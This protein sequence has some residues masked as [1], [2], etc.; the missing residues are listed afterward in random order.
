[1]TGKL[2]L[3]DSLVLFS[4]SCLL[5]EDRIIDCYDCDSLH[6][7]RCRDPF[8]FTVA[9]KDQPPLKSCKGC[10]VKMVQNQ[11]RSNER[12][13]RTCT[14]D[15]QINLFMVDHVCM[16]EGSGKG[17]MCFCEEDRCNSA[18]LCKYDGFLTAVALLLFLAAL[19]A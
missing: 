7:D 19:H 2:F 3:T 8:N 11:G 1:M 17:H 18:N 12:F 6:D 14:D 5:L 15:I 4:L 13:R 16:L 10:C 9:P